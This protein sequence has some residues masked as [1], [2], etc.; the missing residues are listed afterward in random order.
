MA[1]REPS[2]EKR[3]GQQVGGLD[4]QPE[5]TQQLV[6]RNV[7]LAL[8]LRRLERAKLCAEVMSEERLERAIE[9][10]AGDLEGLVELVDVDVR[11]VEEA[12]A[13]RRAAPRQETTASVGLAPADEQRL[14]GEFMTDRMRRWLDEPHAQLDGR[15]PREAVTG[16]RQADVVRL[17]RGLENSTERACRRGEPAADVAWIRGELGLEDSL[18]S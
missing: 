16:E 2:Y 9:T 12:L 15:T 13:E 11:P 3:V 5:V 4:A 1:A 6:V 14:L 17:V 8:A 10:V 18:A 7:D